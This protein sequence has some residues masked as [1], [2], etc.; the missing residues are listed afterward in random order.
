MVSLQWNKNNNT[1]KISKSLLFK[2]QNRAVLF[3]RI[4]LAYS[5]VAW[6]SADG[7]VSLLFDDEFGLSEVESDERDLQ[8]GSTDVLAFIGS[9]T[10][11][12]REVEALEYAVHSS[13]DSTCNGSESSDAEGES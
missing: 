11:T 13:D 6:L 5:A 12:F 10:V 8:D 3:C 9:P 7:V 2:H 4:L 1:V